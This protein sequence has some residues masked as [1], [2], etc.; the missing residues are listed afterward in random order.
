M[1]GTL[2]I[3]KQE[4]WPYSVLHGAYAAESD[5]V[6]KIYDL[7]WEREESNPN[8]RKIKNELIEPQKAPSLIRVVDQAFHRP[9]GTTSRSTFLPTENIL[10]RNKANKNLIPIAV[11]NIFGVTF[12]EKYKALSEKAKIAKDFLAS[13]KDVTVR[14]GLPKQLKDL[15]ISPITNLAA[16]PKISKSQTKN[17]A[18]K[19]FIDAACF[20]QFSANFSPFVDMLKL[21][22][23]QLS[24]QPGDL[25]WALLENPEETI[26]VLLALVWYCCKSDKQ[27]LMK[28]YDALNAA[29]Q[30]QAADAARE[31]V[32]KPANE[33]ALAV[34]AKAEEAKKDA[35]VAARKATKDESE[36][37]KKAAIDAARK[38]TKTVSEEAKKA[39][40]AIMDEAKLQADK[41]SQLAASHVSIFVKD[42]PPDW[43]VWV[44][45]M[46]DPNKTNFQFIA[47]AMK[48]IAINANIV[49]Y[50]SNPSN[51][52]QFIY[53]NVMPGKYPKT[54]THQKDMQFWYDGKTYIHYK[55]GPHNVVFTDCV[56]NMMLNF[57][58]ILAFDPDNKCFSLEYL[59]KKIPGLKLN[60]YL[61]DFF[62]NDHP[63]LKA[64][65][66]MVTPETM[67]LMPVHQAFS[68]I[69]S[70]IP[71]VA[72]TRSLSIAEP[73]IEFDYT[74]P[75]AYGDSLGC[76]IVP[77][78][79]IDLFK[80]QTY[81]PL[82]NNY[83]YI[84][85]YYVL[86]RREESEL[87]TPGKAIC[88]ELVGTLKNFIVLLNHILGLNLFDG[89]NI[90]TEIL[91]HNFIR[92]Y[93][94]QLAARLKLEFMLPCS[95]EE[96]DHKATVKGDKL[97]IKIRTESDEKPAFELNYTGLHAD[98]TIIS[99]TDASCYQELQNITTAMPSYQPNLPSWRTIKIA[100]LSQADIVKI[101]KNKSQS[102]DKTPTFFDIFWMNQNNDLPILYY[103]IFII[104]ELWFGG[105]KPEDLGQGT[106]E[107]ILK[108]KNSLIEAADKGLFGS[109]KNA[110]PH[111]FKYFFSQNNGFVE[112]FSYIEKIMQSSNPVDKI[113]ALQIT[114]IMLTT[115]PRQDPLTAQINQIAETCL[116]D[117]DQKVVTAAYEVIKI[118]NPKFKIHEQANP[119][120]SAA[121]AAPNIIVPTPT[122]TFTEK[123]PAKTVDTDVQPTVK[124]YVQPEETP[125]I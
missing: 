34:T 43:G 61:V 16:M 96:I 11:A 25:A 63:V 84:K 102:S 65:N 54:S 46:F 101:I 108:F 8:V 59:N 9:P 45:S 13:L 37:A 47:E 78:E 88:Y 95:I 24:T 19:Q 27:A 50:F 68:S 86:H 32:M 1:E 5:W 57:I 76:I 31:G 110:L 100:F 94:P 75:I 125:K 109:K 118:Y 60:A 55:N 123:T 6:M 21:G 87:S 52:E 99:N 23:D 93:L 64:S 28:Y 4:Y 80:S 81:M 41:A 35:I 15:A 56:E 70:N 107:D 3:L 53:L 69:V 124:L 90:Y 89:K 10:E 26:M 62:N 97:L 114:K 49:V 7:G 51:Y 98:I 20:L 83:A 40:K 112:A 66:C 120:D 74:W 85:K 117:K 29:A 113:F 17:V 111:I 92:E 122:E 48:Y 71:S 2:S 106:F 72:Y 91:R 121:A 14:E 18:L 104:T 103:Y 38:A 12:S 67:G 30:K 42:T 22:T 73:N 58:C 79:Y 39:A 77:K 119:E 116:Q 33:A 82:P 115:A 44:N 105:H 36:E